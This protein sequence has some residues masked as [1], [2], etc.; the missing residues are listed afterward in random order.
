MGLRQLVRDFN[1]LPLSTVPL[2]ARNDHDSL[3]LVFRIHQRL[4][5]KKILCARS[6][7]VVTRKAPTVGARRWKRRPRRDGRP[8]GHN[9]TKGR[10]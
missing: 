6:I 10:M 1:N 9:Y 3:E 4:P 7:L 8:G 2:E 5:E